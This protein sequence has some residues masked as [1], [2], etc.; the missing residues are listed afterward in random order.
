MNLKIM[1]L[2]ALLAASQD[3]IEDRNK[4]LVELY[5]KYEEAI[6]E[7]DSE[8]E[9]DVQSVDSDGPP[10]DRVRRRRQRR[11]DTKKKEVE[12]EEDAEEEEEDQDPEEQN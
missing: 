4:A 8:D 10:V 5:R 12:A 11:K 2:E 3:E 7:Q 1:Q 6:N 9:E